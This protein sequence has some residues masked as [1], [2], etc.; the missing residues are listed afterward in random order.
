MRRGAAAE[1]QSRIAELIQCGLQLPVRT[2]RHRLNQFIGKL[3]TEHRADLGDLLGCR[4][5]PVESRHQRGVQGRRHRQRRLRCR[6]QHRGNPV[7]MSGAFQHRL[8][9]LFDKQ[10]HPVGAV[11]DLGDDLSGQA[12]IT[13]QSLHQ[14][15]TLAFAEPIKR[16]ARNVSATRPGRLEFGTKR[17]CQQHRQTAHPVD[18]QIQQFARGRVDPVSILK[19]H[20]HRP[21][22]RFGFELTEQ[23]LEQLLTLALRTQTGVRGRTR[24]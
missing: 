12:R 8:G 24:Q 10:R 19:H 4:P 3:A 20:Q 13:G 2:L 9:Q 22:T 23:N 1:Q 5:E 21:A 15:L 14:S 11:D 17:D 6:R 18:G 7:T 16:Q